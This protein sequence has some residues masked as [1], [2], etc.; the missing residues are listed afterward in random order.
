[1][2]RPAWELSLSY[3]PIRAADLAGSFFPVSPTQRSLNNSFAACSR[4]SGAALL[5]EGAA[6]SLNFLVA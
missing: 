6:G 2:E 5:L 1:M 3:Y 4:N